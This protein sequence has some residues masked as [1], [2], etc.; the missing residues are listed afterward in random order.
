M[1]ARRTHHGARGRA[2]G[3]AARG[4]AAEVMGIRH[5]DGDANVG[6]AEPVCLRA[7]A[8]SVPPAEAITAMRA[9]SL[10]G[11]NAGNI[12]PAAQLLGIPD[13]E[14]QGIIEAAR[15]PAAVPAPSALWPKETARQRL[16]GISDATFNRM[17]RA[18]EI[19]HVQIGARVLI[20]PE[21]I[22]AFIRKAKTRKVRTKVGRPHAAVA[23]ARREQAES[24]AGQ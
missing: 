23:N 14:L 6:L 3:T 22:E 20:D 21:D 19:P 13:Y 7:T 1:S 18:G 9:I 12:P 8:V 17:L 10:A 15:Q 5:I 24:R 4:T 11:I 16:G 2:T